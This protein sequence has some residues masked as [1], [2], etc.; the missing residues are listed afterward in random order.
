MYELLT[1]LVLECSLRA[2]SQNLQPIF[3]EIGRY[4]KLNKLGMRLNLTLDLRFHQILTIFVNEFYE[5]VLYHILHIIIFPLDENFWLG[6]K[7]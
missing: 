2:K 7:P 1:L 6:Y 4:W 3:I 5:Y